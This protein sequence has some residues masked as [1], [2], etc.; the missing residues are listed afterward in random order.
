MYMAVQNTYLS[1]FQTLG[2]LGLLLGVFGLAAVMMR[3][4]WERRGELAL[5]RALGF[6]AKK[7]YQISMLEHATL[8]LAGLAAGVFSALVAVGPH[9]MSKPDEIPWAS[10][11]GTIVLVFVAGL[12]AGAI[13][14]RSTLKTPLLAALRRE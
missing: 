4:I 14:I 7:L 12:A 9:A 11:A 2:G 8:L 6:R 5:L 3:S 10:L 1:T 13:C